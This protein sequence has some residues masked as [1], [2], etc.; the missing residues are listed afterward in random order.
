MADFG[1]KQCL[2]CQMWHH[3]QED[4]P[5]CRSCYQKFKWL[6]IYD[7]PNKIFGWEEE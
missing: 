3:Y 2:L 1:S 6:E 7:R 4:W 5:V